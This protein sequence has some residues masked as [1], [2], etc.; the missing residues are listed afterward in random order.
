MFHTLRSD[1]AHAS[2]VDFKIKYHVLVIM[3]QRQYVPT[4]DLFV[5]GLPATMASVA[6]VSYLR[7]YDA[8][9]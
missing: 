5:G 8:A 2:E 7:H 3:S 4:Y 1:G 9:L 6:D